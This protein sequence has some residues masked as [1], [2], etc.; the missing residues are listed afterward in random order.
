MMEEKLLG[1]SV[2]LNAKHRFSASFNVAAF[3]FGIKIERS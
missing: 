3:T 2:S 1:N